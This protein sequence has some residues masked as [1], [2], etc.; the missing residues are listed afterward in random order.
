MRIL[1]DRDGVEELPL[2][3]FIYVSISAIILII[4]FEGIKNVE[5]LS[6]ENEVERMI[7]EMSILIE[8]L[9]R[10]T[11]RNLGSEMDGPMKMTRIEITEEVEYI[12]FYNNSILYKVTGGGERRFLLSENIKIREG[13]LNDSWHPS[14]EGLV[15]LGGRNYL[16]RWEAVWDQELGE[17]YIISH[18]N[19]GIKYEEI[20]N[21]RIL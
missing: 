13:I 4:A 20:K 11:P 16:I 18:Y 19:D 6:L 2:K 17:K 7:A 14:K 12:F 21:S 1:Q 15:L 10:E 9:Q 3:L 5:V 8:A